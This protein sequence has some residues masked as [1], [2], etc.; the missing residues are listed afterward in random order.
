MITLNEITIKNFLSHEDT[1]IHLEQVEKL[2]IDGRSGSGKSSI[3]EAIVW[4]LYGKGRSENRNLVR[5]GSKSASVSLKLIDGLTGTIITRSIS[6]AKNTLVITQNTGTEGQ[7]LPIER[8]GLKD[9]QEW[10]EQVFLHASYELF[11]NSIAYPQ[12]Q[13]D[14]FVKASAS[15]RKDLLLEIVRAGSF[16]DLYD[17][18]RKLIST[19]ETENAVNL[20]KISSLEISIEVNKELAK[21]FESYCKIYDESTTQIKTLEIVE[22]DLESQLR[23]I[24]NSTAQIMNNKRMIK[25]LNDSIT[26]INTQLEINNQTIE[27]FNKLDPEKLLKD[28][29]ESDKIYKE[30]EAIETEIKNN[31]EVSNVYYNYMANI[32]LVFDYSKDIKEINERLVPLLKDSDKCP[33]G[34]ACPWIA[35]IQGQITYLKEQLIDRENKSKEEALALKKWEEIKVPQ[36]KDSTVL[37]QTLKDTQSKYLIL[38]KSK[39]LYSNY[40]GLREGV[41]VRNAKQLSLKLEIEEKTKEIIENEDKVKILEEQLIK[42][43]INKVNS[44]LANLRLSK[45][46]LH[47]TRDES[48]INKQLAINAEKGVKDASTALLGAQESIKKVNNDLEALQTLKEALSPRGIKATVVDFLV[49]ELEQRM[50]DILY[51]MSDFRIRLDTQAPK[52][53][54]GIKEGLFIMLKNPEG[55]ELSIENLSGGERIKV[56]MAIAEALASLMNGVGFRL[57]DECINSLDNESTQSFVEVL[58][59]LQEK[60]PQVL[61]ISHLEAVKEIFEKKIN[62][63]KKGGISEI[64]K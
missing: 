36:I 40:L 8:T 20:S 15:K 30:I 44:D 16:D 29:E 31:N 39:D 46:E 48:S 42:F 53:D 63:I 1:K 41:E 4:C 58:L 19:L 9:Q 52:A 32:P 18:S 21:G 55:I 54:E 51:Q 59:K 12:E 2:L 28:I 7:F 64:E 10:I 60:F 33:A 6:N 23:D 37:Y 38:A 50:N 27:G 17:K 56:S 14:S 24:S 26:S 22:K 43:D 45:Q 5:R 25:V 62:I 3:A 35:P 57:L 47:K 34:D 13:S 61:V 49:P 11:V